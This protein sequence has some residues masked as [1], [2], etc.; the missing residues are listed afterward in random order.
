MKM[1]G[2][3]VPLLSKTRYPMPTEGC[4]GFVGSLSGFVCAKLNAHLKLATGQVVFGPAANAWPLEIT[5]AQIA[6]TTSELV[7]IRKKTPPSKV[8]H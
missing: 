1:V 4:P 5:T 7:L 3:G 8:V 6:A 2:T